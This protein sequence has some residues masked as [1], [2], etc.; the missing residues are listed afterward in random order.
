MTCSWLLFTVEVP[1][2][3]CACAHAHD[4]TL[5]VELMTVC[6]ELAHMQTGGCCQQSSCAGCQQ[7]C[8]SKEAKAAASRPCAGL[9]SA[10]KQ[11]GLAET[12]AAFM[13]VHSCQQ[14]GEDCIN[15]G[16]PTAVMRGVLQA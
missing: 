4:W 9:G 2:V 10:A 7:A 14:T 12:A 15:E 8:R 13:P 6:F 1:C 3:T 5:Q 11:L 16:L